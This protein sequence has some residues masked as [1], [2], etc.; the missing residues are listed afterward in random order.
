MADYFN[1]KWRGTGSLTEFVAEM[2]K[3]LTAMNNIKVIM[4]RYYSG[5]EPTL[6]FTAGQLIFDMA[7]ALIFTLNN[8]EWVWLGIAKIDSNTAEVQNGKL[9]ITVDAN[10]DLD[11]IDWNLTGTADFVS[12]SATISG[13]ELNINV[14][15]NST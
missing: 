12:Y 14:L 10:P 3:L 1:P 15:A 4:P 9:V 5:V 7:E 8:V 2:V 11:N 13:G 6:V